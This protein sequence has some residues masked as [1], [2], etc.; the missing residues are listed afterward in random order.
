MGQKFEIL[1]LKATF[2][3]SWSELYKRYESQT[4]NIAESDLSINYTQI[5][6]R[7]ISPMTV[8]LV[9]TSNIALDSLGNIWGP[10]N[11]LRAETVPRL[12]CK[13]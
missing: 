8:L 4:R 3:A 11:L 9:S 12:K 6:C 10:Q 5:I 7:Y 1:A 2:W 13:I